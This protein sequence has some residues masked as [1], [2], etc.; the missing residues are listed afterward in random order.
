[1]EASAAATRMRSADPTLVP[2][3]FMMSRSFN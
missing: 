1:L 3:N 2:P